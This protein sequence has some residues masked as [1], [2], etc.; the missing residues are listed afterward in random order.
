MTKH[1][2]SS[3]IIIKKQNIQNFP[4]LQNS[5][6]DLILTELD[7]VEIDIRIS[8]LGKKTTVDNILVLMNDKRYEHL[9]DKISERLINSKIQTIIN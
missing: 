5:V 2:G 6:N 7:Y 3:Q 8:T 9:Y 4:I 1:P